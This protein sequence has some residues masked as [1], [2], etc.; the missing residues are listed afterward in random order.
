MVCSSNVD[1][2][3]RGLVVAVN[4]TAGRIT[5]KPINGAMIAATIEEAYEAG[6]TARASGNTIIRSPALIISAGDVRKIVS[7]TDERLSEA[8][9]GG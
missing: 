3:G 2:R 4:L 7:T 8:C 6:A 1:V 5:R 9:L